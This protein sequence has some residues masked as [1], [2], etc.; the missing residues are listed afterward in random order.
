MLQQ[1][2][3]LFFQ[4][5]RIF[6]GARR[7]VNRMLPLELPSGGDPDGARRNRLPNRRGW[8]RRPAAQ[9]E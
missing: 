2:F 3:G 4:A 9:H 5:R 1:Y 6:V 8:S 7:P